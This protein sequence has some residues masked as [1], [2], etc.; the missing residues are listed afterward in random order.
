MNNITVAKFIYNKLKS[1]NINHVFGYS[2]GAILPLLDTFYNSNS[3]KFIKNSNEQCSGYVSEG[4]SKSLNMKKP[5][6]ILS[7]SG[8]G[9]TNIITPLQ[10]AFSDGTPIIAISAQVPTTSIGTDAFQE[11]DA[12]NLT[13]YCTKW[14]Y[15][16]TDKYEIDYILNEAFRIS[17][18]PRKGPVH[19]DIPKNILLETIN[20]KLRVHYPSTKIFYNEKA[21]Y[22]IINRN[23]I[24]YDKIINLLGIAKKPIIIAG[25]GCNDI[26]NELEIFSNKYNIPV[27]TTI[28]GMGCYNEN[29]DLSLE[30]LG[31]H[32]NPAA[33]I[34]VQE[35]DL[36]IGLGTRFDDRTTGNINK[37]ANNAINASY[38][39]KGGIFHIDSSVEQ[40]KKVNKLFNKFYNEHEVDQ[41]LHSINDTSKNFFNIINQYN[42]KTN[43]K[44]E[45][46]KKL[47]IIKM[48][49]I[50]IIMKIKN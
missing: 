32:G 28:H 49:I 4:Y 10:N 20:T 27:T 44:K 29:N 24:N 17:M 47:N 35:A 21:N 18:S 30:M 2:G 48:Y 37:Y 25:Q 46:L 19:I 1:K 34:C 22:K 14:N 45:W 9:L 26:K 33:N 43:D 7:T 41:F 40:I 36:I 5:G 8:P 15:Q 42:I 38:N 3:I 11:C 12:I 50:I 13:K 39:N 6:I 16:I 31:M 23:N